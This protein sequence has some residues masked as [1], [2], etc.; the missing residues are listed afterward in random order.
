MVDGIVGMMDGSLEK[1]DGTRGC[2]EESSELQAMG[3]TG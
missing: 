2:C 3:S 1:R